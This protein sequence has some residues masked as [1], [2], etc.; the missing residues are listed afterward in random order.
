MA[1]FYLAIDI[2][3]D[4]DNSSDGD[5]N[6]SNSVDGDNNNGNNES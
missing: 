6:D 5:N 4:G 1:D 3:V 2:T